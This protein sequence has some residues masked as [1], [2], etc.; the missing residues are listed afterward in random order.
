MATKPSDWD[1]Q[2]IWQ[3]IIE[4]VRAEIN[5][6]RV[7]TLGIDKFTFESDPPTTIPNEV[8]DFKN[9]RIVER[10]TKGFVEIQAEFMLSQTQ[11]DQEAKLHTARTLAVMAAKAIALGEDAYFFQSS[12]REPQPDDA[13]P[14]RFPG[15]IT[16][17]NW[18]RK[19]DLGLLAEANPGDANDG[20][21]SK[22]T[23]PI[24]VLRSPKSLATWGE[25][26]FKAVTAGIARLESKGQAREY[27]LF[28][29]T[30]AYADT[31]APPSPASL[32]TTADRI[33]PL[34]MR[35]FYSSAVLPPEEGLLIALGGEPMKLFIGPVATVKYDR[36]VQGDYFFQV[37]ERVQYIVRDPRAMVLLKFQGQT[38]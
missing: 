1:Q 8:I 2:T 23:L 21:L 37:V 31:F 10:A 11:V 35:G 25:N 13:N 3:D 14:V 32:V 24:N 27:A 15:N 29:P 5:K 9:F 33:K 28:L 26:T 12:N 34:V 36:L 7:S 6:V 30:E 18:N 19:E 16:I 20:D 38:P 4:S 22:V 17:K